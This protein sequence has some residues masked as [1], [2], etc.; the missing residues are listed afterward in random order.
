MRLTPINT[1]PY[2]NGWL[3][4]KNNDKGQKTSKELITRVQSQFI[5]DA[6]T[7]NIR[8]IIIDS[9]TG[10]KTTILHT[11]KAED[12]AIFSTEVN[13]EKKGIK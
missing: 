8:E 2:F 9:Q 12:E 13:D 1:Q 4:R 11:K 7:I 5:E 10:K 6:K 3:S